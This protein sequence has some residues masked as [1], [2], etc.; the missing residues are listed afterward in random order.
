MALDQR[1]LAENFRGPLDR[2]IIQCY[3]IQ[4]YADYL[5]LFRQAGSYKAIGEISPLYLYSPSAAERICQLNPDIKIIAILR[6]PVQRAFSNYINYVQTGLETLSTFE[7]ALEIES[8]RIRDRWGPYPFW[9]Y[10]QLGFYANQLHRYYDRFPTS[11][12][13]IYRYDKFIADPLGVLQDIFKFLE[14]DETF[15]PD[16]KQKYNSSHMPR[17]TTLHRLLLQNSLLKEIVR[18]LFRH[19]ALRKILSRAWHRIYQLNQ[20][21]PKLN[22][23]TEN[24]LRHDYSSDLLKL[25]DLINQDLS[26]WIKFNS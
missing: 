3:S 10:R 22:P 21:Q 26:D 16:V 1:S 18:Y 24:K 14:V 11:Q 13:R 7:E 19:S 20:A 9:H 23:E 25:Q 17:N 2:E 4:N 6:D 5:A 8:A 12:I 15:K